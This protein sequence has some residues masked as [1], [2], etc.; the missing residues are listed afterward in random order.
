MKKIFVILLSLFA[1]LTT[2]ACGSKKS[3]EGVLFISALEAGYGGDFLP[4]LIEKFKEYNPDVEVEYDIN[5]LV[6]SKADPQLR[7]K[8]TETDL[9][10]INGINYKDLIERNDAIE[11]I[12][13][14]FNSKP[15]KGKDTE[16]ITIKDKMRKDFIDYTT[17][18]D[19]NGVEKHYVF[20]WASGPCG[21]IANIDVLDHIY[22]AGNYKLPNTTDELL[23]MMEDIKIKNKTITIGGKE[24]VIFPLIW[25]G[26]ACEYWS[27]LYYVWFAQY[28]G[29]K[30][31][32][33]FWA[34]TDNEGSYSYDVYLS[35]GRLEG[36]KVLEEIVK[37]AKKYAYTGSITLEHTQ[38]QMN[39]LLGRAAFIPNG[40]WLENEMKNSFDGKVNAVTLKTPI[41]SSLGE[42][43]GITDEVLSQIVSAIDN[44][45]EAVSGV[46]SE[47]F[48]RVKEARKYIFNLGNTH[49]AFIP[50][51]SN[52]KEI[53]KDF[54]RFL[55]TDEAIEIFLDTAG[56]VMP[57]NYEISKEKYNTLS[58][59]QKNKIDITKDCEYVFYDFRDPIRYRGGLAEFNGSQRPEISLALANN[60]KTAVQIVDE[61]YNYVKKMWN[62]FISRV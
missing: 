34:A 11:D 41:I 61:E 29:K 36:L 15:K 21:L 13:D 48:N 23:E 6:S 50:S 16:N 33:N 12:T 3:K 4:A 24:E 8:R 46:S 19:N 26:N 39:F 38:A 35:D 5:P 47:V 18:V 25:S 44:K 59:F 58:P 49:T 43:L 2:T 55:A 30:A 52:A 1:I 42:K 17:Y 10:I 51:F 14:V 28:D 37:D 56:S 53:A 9:Y 7:S 40:D 45:E 20:P 32:D 22:G 62:V 31:Y 60:P 57:F 54:L 27:Y